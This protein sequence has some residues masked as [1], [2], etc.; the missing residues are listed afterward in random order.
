MPPATDVNCTDIFKQVLQV[1]LQISFASSQKHAYKHH[2]QVTC[3]AHISAVQPVSARAHLK[4]ILE[5]TS[6]V[7][8]KR[9]RAFA[10]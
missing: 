4:S 6:Q 10:V 7:I 2:M 5:H 9:S 8:S 3:N 1:E